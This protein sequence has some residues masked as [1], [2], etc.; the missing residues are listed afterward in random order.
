MNQHLLRRYVRTMILE[1][2]EFGCTQ[3]S[4]GFITD[5]GEFIDISETEDDHDS[6]IWD[7]VDGTLDS[8]SIPPGWIK[9][10]N[11]YEL[12]INAPSWEAMSIEQWEGL[13]QM[14]SECKQH[15]KWLQK[16]VE[17]RYISFGTMEPYE[18]HEQL[19]V[20]L[21]IKK[22]RIPNGMD[23]FYGMLLGEL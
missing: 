21:F 6:Y 20:P 8:G 9:C 19:T 12:W 23:S 4:L 17:T 13:I 22:Y 1:S 7:N 16:E 15:S 11:S 5:S 18:G 3:H 10:S 14:W 2:H